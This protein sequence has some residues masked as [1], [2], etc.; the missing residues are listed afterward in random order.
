MRKNNA[1]FFGTDHQAIIKGVVKKLREAVTL[2]FAFIAN[3]D[4]LH[5]MMR[6]LVQ[7]LDYEEGSLC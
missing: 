2:V 6:Q 7:I 1:F 4:P 3:T 5:C